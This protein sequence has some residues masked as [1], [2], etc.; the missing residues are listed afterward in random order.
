VVTRES[1]ES[2]AWPWAAGLRGFKVSSVILA[3]IDE[4]PQPPPYRT[5]SLIMIR[6]R[7]P[8]QGRADA[9]PPVRRPTRSVAVAANLPG[10]W[11]IAE[12]F[13]AATGHR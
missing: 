4:L 6:S 1:V 7:K 8:C 11:P 2:S 5:R 3:V 10:R 13:T 9:P 12:G